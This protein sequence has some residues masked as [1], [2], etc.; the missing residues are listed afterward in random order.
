MGYLYRVYWEGRI[1]SAHKLELP[2]KSK[3]QDLHGHEWKIQVWIT[4][5]PNKYGILFDYSHLKELISKYDHKYLNV[6]FD[7]NPT[8]EN[9]AKNFVKIIELMVNDPKNYSGKIEKIKV[10]VWEDATSY[11]EYE[12][13]KILQI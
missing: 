10:R 9:L 6:I 5:E 8:A 11:A 12:E 7:F 2:Y 3:C 4:G 13:N 1:K